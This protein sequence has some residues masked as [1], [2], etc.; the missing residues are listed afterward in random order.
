MAGMNVREQDKKVILALAGRID[1]NNA[2]DTEKEIMDILS[3]HPGKVPAFDAKDLAYISSA[4]LRVLM[5]IRKQTGDAVE[6]FDVSPEVY[7]IFETTGF[8][9]LL[10]VRKKLRTIDVS[11]CEKI[12]EGGNGA[13]YRLDNDKIVKVYRPWV[14]IDAIERERTFARTAFVNGIP[15][16]IAY[17]TVRVGDCY[18][19]VFELLDSDTLGHAMSAHPEKLEA[20]VDQYVALARTLHSTHVPKGSFT[21]IREI[22][23]G[24][25]DNLGKWCSDEEIALLHSLVDEIPEAD[26]VTHNDLHP[27]NIMLQDGE[28]VL[29][30]M[31]EVTMGPPICDLTSIY[32]HMII[33]PQRYAEVMIRSVGMPADL[34]QKTGHMFFRKYTGI[35]D[36]KEMESFYQKL[37]LLYTLNVSLIVGNG[38]ESAMK[39]GDMIMNYLLR[40]TLIP[41]EKTIRT[42]LR[43]A[44]K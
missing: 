30:D 14:G 7:D 26:T 17:D 19:I 23:H 28:L 15:S 38:S 6:V 43:D 8:T 3:A 42:I 9:E 1:T 36:E 32:R 2:A 44:A 12:G 29:I 11:S 25:A 35:T 34:I 40:Q 33:G 39:R 18:G 10:T 20:Y 22:Y 24:M 5:K 31:Q 4:G 13:V 16:V 37:G 27:G 41:N 21:P